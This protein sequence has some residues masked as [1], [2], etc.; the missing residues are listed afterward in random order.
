MWKKKGEGGQKQEALHFS[1]GQLK[2]G[3]RMT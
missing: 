1:G 2:T 3:G